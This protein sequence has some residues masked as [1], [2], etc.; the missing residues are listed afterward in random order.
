MLRPFPMVAP[1]WMP[2]PICIAALVLSLTGC[3]PVYLPPPPQ[4]SEQPHRL[5]EILDMT[6]GRPAETWGSVVS[7]MHT[8]FDPHAD[9]RWAA[10]SVVFHF[11]VDEPAG[12]SLSA[13]IT[14][15]QS[16]L[17]KMGPQRVTFEVNGETVGTLRLDASRHYDLSFPVE[18]AVLKRS[19]PIVVRMD[20]GPCLAQQYG[21]PYC[22]LLHKIGFVSQTDRA[23]H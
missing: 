22:V 7:G 18:A 20:T 12:W 1:I 19:S 13:R 6:G 23:P 5:M 17:D 11:K 21:P 3:S 16:I 14:A 15:A 9:W 4:R 8:S 10:E 2:A